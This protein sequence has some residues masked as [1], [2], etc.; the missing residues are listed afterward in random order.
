MNEKDIFAD[1]LRNVL[2]GL[3]F[4]NQMIM[5][6]DYLGLTGFAD[7]QRQ[8]FKDEN[9]EMVSL[10]RYYV[11]CYGLIPNEANVEA[12]N[13][14][15]PEWWEDDRTLI[16]AERKR[17]FVKFGIET[18]RDWEVKSKARYS[19]AYFDLDGVRDAGATER[20]GILVQHVER[21]LRYVSGLMTKLRGCDYDMIAMVEMDRCVMKDYKRF[22]KGVRV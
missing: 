2:E 12:R 20:L 3:M 4:H 5:Y 7:L 6:F 22:M 15:P 21:E 18:W 16:T 10:Q 14:I 17:E 19:K 13:Y 11:E 8:R 1:V 9:Q